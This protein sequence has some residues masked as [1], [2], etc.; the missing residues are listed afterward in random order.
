MATIERISRLKGPLTIRCY[1]CG[2]R[3]TWSVEE[4][5]RRLGGECSVYQARQALRCSVCGARKAEFS[6]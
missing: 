2:H 5:S 1:A 6:S 3:V 4:A